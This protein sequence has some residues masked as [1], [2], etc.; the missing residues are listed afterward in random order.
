[1]ALAAVLAGGLAVAGWAIW[2]S[3]SATPVAAPAG[4]VPS[5]GAG[6]E[7]AKI[8]DPARFQVITKAAAEHERE[9]RF[10]AAEAVLRGGVDE[11]VEDQQL[12]VALAEYLVRRGRF[13]EAYGQYVAALTIGPRDPALEFKAGMMA[14]VTGEHERAAEHFGAAQRG[15]PTEPT[16][17]LYLASAQLKLGQLDDARANLVR[18][19]VLDESNATAWGTLAELELR[20]N[21]PTLAV[22][23]ARKARS[24]DPKEPAWKLLEARAL[25]RTGE[26][27]Q[28]LMLLGTLD[29]KVRDQVEYLRTI[30]EC[31]AMLDRREDAADRYSVAADRHPEDAVLAYEAAVWAERVGRIDRARELAGRAAKLGHEGAKELV[32]RLKGG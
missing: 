10:E 23:H 24:G 5:G 1:M 6:A 13:A 17:P 22:Q 14:S 3:L 19:T 31:L 20:T 29:E 7:A 30:G 16:Y 11:Y 12:R 32:G 26:P 28:A 9:Q 15:D 21:E 2:R 8:A 27:E 25:K 18:A 4:G